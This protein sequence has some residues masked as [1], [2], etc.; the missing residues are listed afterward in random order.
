MVKNHLAI[1]MFAQFIKKN[2]YIPSLEEFKAM[3]Y[4]K[5]HYYR[6]KKDFIKNTHEGVVKIDMENVKETWKWIEDYEQYYMVSSKGRVL[7]FDIDGIEPPHL[8]PIYEEENK[9]YTFIFK[10]G[11]QNKYYIK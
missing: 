9:K 1:E 2:G 8:L 6:I 10:D 11:I 3:G 5:A 4:S 7:E